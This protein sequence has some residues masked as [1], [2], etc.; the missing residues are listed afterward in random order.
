MIESLKNKPVSVQQVRFFV[1]FLEPFCSPFSNIADRVIDVNDRALS[2]RI[3]Y[4]SVNEYAF[5]M[6]VWYNFFCA[7]LQYVK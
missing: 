5:K 6:C 1:L 3:N 4:F 7:V 2:F